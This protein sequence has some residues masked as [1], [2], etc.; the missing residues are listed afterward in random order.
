MIRLVFALRRQPNLS[1][2]E[3]QDYWLNQ[4]APLVASFATDLNILRY[5][6]TH[7]IDSPMN[8]AAQKARGKM[9]P[10]FDGVAELWWSSESELNEQIGSASGKAA[11][12]SAALLEDESKFID[13]PNSPLWFAYE[14]PQVNPTPEDITAKV[15]S[16]ILRVFFPLRH[17]T[18][19][20]EEEARHYWLTHH[21]PIVRS[22]AEATRTLCYRQVHRAN[23]PLDKGI[24][25]ARG[26]R[27]ESYLGHAE[28]WVDMGTAP[29]T[30]EARRANAAFIT[31]EHNFIDME[32]STFLFGKEHTIID[33]R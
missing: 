33:K 14:Y 11:A 31:D 3:F 16:N 5:V 20:S 26:T 13:L 29:G 22:H 7:T 12:A 28:A 32:R 9:E 8:E 2:S 4:H 15:K 6:Q 30:D 24:Q 10:H 25:A 19:L 23:S 21:G 27:V 17:Q 1:L 18:T